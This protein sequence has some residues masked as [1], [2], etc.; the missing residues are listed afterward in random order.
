[1]LGRSRLR[2]SNYKEHLSV[3]WRLFENLLHRNKRHLE[4]LPSHISSTVSSY[5]GTSTFQPNLSRM[6][7]A[8]AS[9]ASGSRCVVKP[10]FGVVCRPP[11]QRKTACQSAWAEKPSTV[12]T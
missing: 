8:M 12:S 11:S 3:T 9:A 6:C 1:M 2:P 4:Y 7:C 10:F 5:S